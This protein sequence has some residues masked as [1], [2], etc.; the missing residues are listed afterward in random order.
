MQASAEISDQVL[1]AQKEAESHG[2]LHAGGSPSNRDIF[3][4]L[5]AEMP[6]HLK[7][8]RQDAGY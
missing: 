4:G 8:Q 1:A 6:P 5:Y 3:E 2:T 7:R